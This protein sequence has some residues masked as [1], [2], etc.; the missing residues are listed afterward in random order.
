MYKTYQISV[1]HDKPEDV[2]MKG[3]D[4]F[5][6]SGP[7]IV[8]PIKYE[9]EET[10]RKGVQEGRLPEN[11]GPYHLLYKVDGQLIAISVL[12]ITPLGVSSVYCIWDPDWAWASLGKV[13]A[14]YEIS[15]ARRLGAAGAGKEFGGTGVK[16]VYMGYWVP[17][18]QKMKYKSEYAPSYL[19]DPGTNVFHELTRD[20]EMYLV[21]HP[22]GY[23]PFKDIEAEAKKSQTKKL[24]VPSAPKSPIVAVSK[25]V[26]P[27]GDEDSDEEGEPGDLPT[28]PP[29]GFADPA[30]ISEKEVDEVLVLLSL[31]KSY[32]GGKQLFQISELEFVDSSYVRETVRQ[33]LAAVGKEWIANERDRVTGAAAEKG[34]MFL[35]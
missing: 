15:L 21:N 24:D 28:P 9:D 3:F 2:T 5:L 14:L 6:C 29:P 4:R 27:G 20:L 12:D 33:M 25:E 32:F 8:T 16:W 10:G 11:Y 18:C 34:I 19:L 13:T 30:T 23:F 31:R 22:R 1:H 7:L 17:N 26:G 35:G